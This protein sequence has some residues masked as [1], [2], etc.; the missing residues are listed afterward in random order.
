MNNP[1]DIKTND[2]RESDTIVNFVIFCE[3]SVS[4]P[5]Y[6]N[7]FETNKI[8]VNCIKNQKSMMKNVI[9]AIHHCETTGLLTHE[10]GEHC[11]LEGT[12]VW[13][14]FDRDKEETEEKIQKGDIEFNASIDTAERKGLNIAW[15]NDSFELWVLLHFQEVETTDINRQ[16]Y[17]DKLTEIFR[18]LPNPNEDL[19]KIL[20]H[21]SYSYKRDFKSE[22]N[23]RNVVRNEIIK[24]TKEAIERAKTLESKYQNNSLQN[25]QKSPITLVYKLVEE[26][27]KTGGKDV[28]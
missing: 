3:D 25:H 4:E 21:Q 13:C 22:N 2:N 27:I 12:Q 24:N 18:Q 9:N 10:N 5:V 17:Y 11:M 1:W 7:Y 6:F 23:F 20:V 15:S 16:L 26:L 28:K 19:Q 8:K 14:V